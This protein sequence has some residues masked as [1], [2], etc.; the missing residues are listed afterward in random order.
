MLAYSSSAEAAAVLPSAAPS[1]R[2]R[3]SPEGPNCHQLSL[4]DTH[5]NVAHWL[6][7]GALEQ[8]ARQPVLLWLQPPA[9]PISAADC[10]EIGAVLLA[11]AHADTA[12]SLSALLGQ[13]LLH[14][15]FGGE[16]LRG[17]HR[18]RCLSGGNGQVWQLTPVSYA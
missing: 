8:L 7:P 17:Y 1:F 18:L 2:V 6:I 3:Q 14:L 11:P 4:E 5:G 15:H 10:L 13:G 12:P 9:A 16:L